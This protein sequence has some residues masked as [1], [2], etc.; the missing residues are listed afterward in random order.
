MRRREFITALGGPAV[1]PL[2]A[3]AQQAGKIVTV[4]VL[5]IEALLPIDT[6]RQAL[7]D[8]GHVEGENMRG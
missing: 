8:L 2:A 5:A 1:W 4:G 7:N 6:F 3:R